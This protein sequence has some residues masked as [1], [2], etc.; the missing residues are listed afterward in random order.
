M[1][2]EDCFFP[3]GITAPVIGATIRLNNCSIDG[4]LTG[5]A[6]NTDAIVLDNC[7]VGNASTTTTQ[8]LGEWGSMIIR[9]TAFGPKSSGAI[10]LAATLA[11]LQL[12]AVSERSL[13][14]TGS[15]Q[16]TI[17]SSTNAFIALDEGQQNAFP[18]DGV[19]SAFDFTM[20][21]RLYLAP[22]TLAADKTIQLGLAFGPQALEVK[23]IDVYGTN[24]H[25]LTVQFSSATIRT[26]SPSDP[27]PTRY[28]FQVSEDNAIIVFVGMEN[29]HV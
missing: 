18:I 14:S 13:F 25:T 23:P 27:V 17:G 10:A 12:D 29:L 24:G 11:S 5:S 6:I 7:R 16:A 9:N 1:I 8:T 20:G 4:N 15:G 22:T 28:V 21:P 3:A 26:I 2:C 19:L